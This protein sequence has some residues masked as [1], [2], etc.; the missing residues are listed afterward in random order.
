MAII[1]EIS[2]KIPPHPHLWVVNFQGWGSI[3]LGG[4]DGT[5][6]E[7]RLQVPGGS[8][9]QDRVWVPHYPGDKNA[10]LGKRFLEFWRQETVQ[11]TPGCRSILWWTMQSDISGKH[12]CGLNCGL[13]KPRHIFYLNIISWFRFPEL[14]SLCVSIRPGLH[15]PVGSVNALSLQKKPEGHGEQS[16]RVILPADRPMVPSGHGD[17]TDEPSTQ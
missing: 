5:E 7:Q 2:S 10:P 8:C 14:F 11:R 4:K 9:Q 6:R 17:G 13:N 1:K 12:H 16:A 3:A 15:A